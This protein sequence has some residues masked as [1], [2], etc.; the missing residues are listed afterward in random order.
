MR[1]LG[2]ETSSNEALGLS[3]AEAAARLGQFG[4]NALAETHVGVLAKL[5]AYFWDRSL[6]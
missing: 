2:T 1:R 5:A 6:G 3:E 4:E